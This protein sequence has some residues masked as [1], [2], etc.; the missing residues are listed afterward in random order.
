ME[1]ASLATPEDAPLLLAMGRLHEAKAHDVS[2]QALTQLPEGC[3]FHPRCPFAVE[4][5]RTGEIAL[6]PAAPDHAVACIRWRDVRAA[7]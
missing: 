2:L 5:C 7:A 4:A 1:R 6:E 3:R